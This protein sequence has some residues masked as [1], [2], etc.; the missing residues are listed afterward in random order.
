KPPAMGM[1]IA[2][3]GCSFDFNPPIAPEPNK[4][5][6]PPEAREKARRFII[7]A[8]T[9][10]NDR[11]ATMLCAEWEKA[12]GDKGAFWRARDAMA[13]AGDKASETDLMGTRVKAPDRIDWKTERERIDLAAV[14]TRLLGPAPGRRGER[15]RRLWWSCPFHTDPNPSFA[16]DPGKPFWKCYGC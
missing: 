14:A 11:K 8:L 2:D 13:E 6:R 9:R 1:T 15:G 10:E 4:G 7:D 3:A 5:G 16:V 12:G